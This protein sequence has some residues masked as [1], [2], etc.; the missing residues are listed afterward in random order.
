MDLYGLYSY[1]F[2]VTL[3]FILQTTYDGQGLND[4]EWHTVRVRR[5]YKRLLLNVD[6]GVKVKG[7]VYII[8]VLN[9]SIY[10]VVS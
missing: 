10:T 5:R 2:P 6:D 9:R 7:K 3:I 4:N 8:G 1:L